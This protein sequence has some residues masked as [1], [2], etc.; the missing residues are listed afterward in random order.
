MR[1]LITLLLVILTLNGYSQTELDK[2]VFEKINTYR[3]SKGLSPLKWDDKTFN[4]SKHHTE[5]QV[6]NKIVGHNEKNNTPSPKS[7]LDY[8]GVDYFYTGENCAKVIIGITEKYSNDEYL[9]SE[10]VDGWK[11]SPYHNKIMLGENYKFGGVSCIKDG[12]LLYSTLNV[13]GLY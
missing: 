7:R 9:S 10:I 12:N 4:A 8:Y 13:Y 6:K 2:L 1:Q 3:L 5:Y 11:N